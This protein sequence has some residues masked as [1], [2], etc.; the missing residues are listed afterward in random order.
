MCALSDAKS[1]VSVSDE[2]YQKV[3]NWCNPDQYATYQD[4]NQAMEEAEHVVHGRM[5]VHS[6]K[7]V[8]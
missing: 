7:N 1:V 4:N 5:I 2:W 8:Q 6:E 3:A